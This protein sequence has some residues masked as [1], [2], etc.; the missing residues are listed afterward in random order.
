MSSW[1]GARRASDRHP[2]P[3]PGDSAASSRRHV[4]DSAHVGSPAA[5]TVPAA[6]GHRQPPHICKSGRAGS[7]LPKLS[8]SRFPSPRKTQAPGSRCLLVLAAYGLSLVLI[9][10][11]CAGSRI[12]G[13]PEDPGDS[14]LGP[15]VTPRT[16]RATCS[17]HV[18]EA[19]SGGP[20]PPCRDRWEAFREVPSVRT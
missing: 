14:Q 16:H 6:S 10:A 17:R 8:G 12:R 2:I 18:G 20:P 9:I 15:S 1:E 7:S 5:S 3:C 13:R 19:W 11:H 4:T